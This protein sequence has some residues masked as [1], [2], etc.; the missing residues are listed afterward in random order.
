MRAPGIVLEDIAVGERPVGLRLPF[1]YGIVTIRSAVEAVAEVRLRLD[2]GRHGVG[3]AAEMMAP[4]W[5]AKNPARP[6]AGDVEALR[7]SVALAREAYGGARRWPS[8]FGA[9]AATAPDLRREGGRHGLTALE[10]GFGQA[11]VDK[12]IL[13][14]LCDAT[15]LCF[16]DMVRTNVPG[17]D[18]SAAPDLSGVDIPK[19]LEK[20]RPQAVIRIRHTVGLTDPLT[21]TEADTDPRDGRPV[22]L[23]AVIALTGV[24]AFKIKLSGCVAADADR[25]LRIAAVVGHGP[26]RFVTL[27][28]NEGFDSAAAFASYWTALRA[29]RGLRPFLDRVAVIEQPVARS[30]AFAGTLPASLR[31]MPLMIDESDEADDSF[32]R[33]RAQGYRGVSSK[34]CK[35]V[36]R[37]I[38]NAIRARTWNARAK[39]SRYFVSAEDLC[40]QVGPAL[41]QDL[42]LAALIGCTQAERNGHH[43]GDGVTGLAP[44][45]RERAARAHPRFYAI[46]GG[47]LV[48]RINGGALD[49]REAAQP[50]FYACG[51]FS[52]AFQ[53]R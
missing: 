36:Y 48:P 9:H 45:T 16:A 27:D 21:R 19:A 12:A 37:A 15:G 51:E 47:A 6:E 11:L 33:A 38:L 18:R 49:M 4:K 7:Q 53:V 22:S 26:D 23:D 14:A 52:A 3:V 31:T 1:R 8:A 50:G 2:G 39:R 32:V 5:F 41:Q 24:T 10:A 17:I 30:A 29:D 42:A 28:G 20:Y 35:G 25:L 40:T 13:A 44:A 34:S 43:Y 46:A